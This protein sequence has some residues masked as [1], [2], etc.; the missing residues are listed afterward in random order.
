M[1]KFCLNND[2][3]WANTA[4]AIIATEMQSSCKNVK[5][6]TTLSKFSYL[7]KVL[8]KSFSQPMA[9]LSKPRLKTAAELKWLNRFH[10]RQ[11]HSKLVERKVVSTF[12]CQRYAQYSELK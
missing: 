4:I 9:V 1:T 12:I 2:K 10:S 6:F 5:T 3:I 7:K 11:K 8:Q